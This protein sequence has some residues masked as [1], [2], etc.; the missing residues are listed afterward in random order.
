MPHAKV[1]GLLVSEEKILK[2]L[3]YMD[4]AAILVK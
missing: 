2:I 4:M 1:V 3:Q